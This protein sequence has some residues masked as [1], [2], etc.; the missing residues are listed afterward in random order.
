VSEDWRVRIT[1][2]DE[3]RT[4]GLVDELRD[5]RLAAAARER[6]GGA[7]VISREGPEIFLYAGSQEDAGHAEDVLRE[8]LGS[9]AQEATFEQARWH[10]VEERWEPWSQPLPR[11]ADEIAAEER[12]RDA[13]EA[14]ESRQAGSPLWEVRIELPDRAE[15]AA[16]EHRLEDEGITAVRRHSYLL[17]GAMSEGE[18]A[19]L[20][21]RLAGIAPPDATLTIEGS[22]TAAELE[23]P[24]R[25]LVAVFGG[26]A[27]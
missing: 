16:L 7:V 15:A 8:V 25:S 23:R 2:G 27:Q 6:L 14:A 21:T 5:G 4:H 18:A 17:V 1:L 10:E 26:L 24:H 11:S 9:R 19:A 3:G 22:I 12:R 13:Q 20:R